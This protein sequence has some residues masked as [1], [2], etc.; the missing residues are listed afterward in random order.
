MKLSLVR[1]CETESDSKTAKQAGKGRVAGEGIRS[2][3]EIASGLRYHGFNMIA[4][5][6]LKHALRTASEIA[7]LNLEVIPFCTTE[8]LNGIRTR[9]AE[10]GI[11]A[12]MKPEGAEGKARARE[13]ENSNERRLRWYLYSVYS[14]HPEG[15]VLFVCDTDVI[16]AYQNM[17]V[18]AKTH[19]AGRDSCV[20][21]SLV[22]TLNVTRA[23]FSAKLMHG[24][25][26]S[27][28]AGTLLPLMRP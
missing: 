28:P 4:S 23:W 3:A 24:S 7:R 2:E 12:N 1:P 26:V 18:R 8:I 17:A 22:L 21:S 25:A 14:A 13:L 19:A 6:Q 15:H 20:E 11:Q 27:G 10:G 9:Y 5:S 16:Q